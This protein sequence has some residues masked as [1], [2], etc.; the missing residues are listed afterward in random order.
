MGLT[1]RN[2]G[3]YRSGEGFRGTFV[4][5]VRGRI[6]RSVACMLWTCPHEDLL[7]PERVHRLVLS[8]RRFAPLTQTND[9]RR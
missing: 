3:G 4:P 6:L 5:T 7:D 2:D 1:L 8:H 9:E